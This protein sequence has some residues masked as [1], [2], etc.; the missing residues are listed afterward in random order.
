MNPYIVALLMLCEAVFIWSIVQY[1][2]N[3]AALR[4]ELPTLDDYFAADGWPSEDDVTPWDP[5]PV[6]LVGLAATLDATWPADPNVPTPAPIAVPD[7]AAPEP[8]Q[9]PLPASTPPEHKP[10]VDFSAERETARLETAAYVRGGLELNE[11]QVNAEAKRLLGYLAGPAP[12]NC[13]AQAVA[14][15]QGHAEHHPQP[16][17]VLA[18]IRQF[19][20]TRFE[21]VR[22]PA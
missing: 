14:M 5:T 19:G 11:D 16:V 4:A 15:M 7:P 2:A 13:V 10:S 22:A 6:D 18:Y 9:Y 21:I 3:R 12:E 1:R 8:V 17:P 20:S